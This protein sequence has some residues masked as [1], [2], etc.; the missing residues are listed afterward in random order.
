MATVNVRGCATQAKREYID[1]ELFKLS[2]D[3]CGVQETRCCWASAET[4]NFYWYFSPNKSKTSHRGTGILVRKSSGIEIKQFRPVS[5]NLCSAW[6]CKDSI[7]FLMIV[8]HIPSDGRM[9]ETFADLSNIIMKIPPEDEYVV[10]GDFNG[11]I[12][13]RDTT[14]YNNLVGKNLLHRESNEN[15]FFT[16]L[17]MTQFDLKACNTFSPSKS[18]LST[19]S[20]NISQSQIDHVLL[21]VTSKIQIREKTIKA[22]KPSLFSTDH[23]IL[24]ANIRNGK[25]ISRN[26]GKRKYVA[27]IKKWNLQSLDDKKVK[28][29][30]AAAVDKKL[31]HME[32]TSN[33]ATQW[34]NLKQIIVTAATETIPIDKKEPKSPKTRRA[35]SILQ[36]KLQRLEKFKDV[37]RCKQEVGWARNDFERAK[38]EHTWKEWQKF[39]SNIEQV[40]PSQRVGK[41]Y[42]F[43]KQ[44]KS[45]SRR[46]PRHYVNQFKWLEAL[47]QSV[48]D[49]PS[50]P[51]LQESENE[52]I[53]APSAQ[54]VIMIIK[55]FK[56]GKCP[57][58]DGIPVELLKHASEEYIEK[59]SELIRKVWDDNEAPNE[60]SE[61]VQVKYL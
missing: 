52:R 38:K 56:N 21:P 30:F 17:L 25:N 24:T 36:K 15:G 39:F 4:K 12:G 19:W 32:E 26:Q 16:L 5:E 35:Y 27:K 47:C 48:I 14:D 3:I 9:T 6:L 31:K 53:P 55:G 54:E 8:V 37:D 42:S 60:F 23:K 11:H 7:G 10:L 61:T 43:L 18:V 57:G 20:N 50:L 29:L 59:I 51:L 46:K 40:T 28:Q 2:I 33:T 1:M 49:D 58:P 22:I 34:H 44:F 45:Q 13:S 41:T